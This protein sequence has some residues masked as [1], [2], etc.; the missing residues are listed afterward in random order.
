MGRPDA[1]E[2]PFVDGTHPVYRAANNGDVA[3]VK[4]ALEPL[5]G[6]KR[7]RWE[8]VNSRNEDA[9][10]QSPLHI[11]ASRGY[12]PMATLL[13][14]AGAELLPDEKGRTPLHLAATNDDK[15]MVSLLLKRCRDPAKA[16]SSFATGGYSRP[17]A[18][19]HLCKLPEIRKML[20][21]RGCTD[22]DG[23]K[24]R[25]TLEGVF[26]PMGYVKPVLW[27]AGAT[28]V[29]GLVCGLFIRGKRQMEEGH[30]RP[31]FRKYFTRR[32]TA[33]KKN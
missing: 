9:G 29:V 18:P 6:D 33:V 20:F 7:A 31:E 5:S 27:V 16:K 32:R 1:L 21:F 14:D 19:I 28:S 2:L 17:A 11:A 30:A 25:V 23:G 26:R 4:R 12:L 22:E 15:G 13:L 10:D 3:A 8:A 24:T